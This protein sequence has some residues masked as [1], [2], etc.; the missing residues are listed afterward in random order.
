MFRQSLESENEVEE[1][2]EP[3]DEEIGSDEE[4]GEDAEDITTDEQIL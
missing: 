1:T 4:T 3:L 2:K